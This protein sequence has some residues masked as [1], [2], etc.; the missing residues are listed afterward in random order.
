[1]LAIK[2]LFQQIS[3]GVSPYWTA[4]TRQD[5]EYLFLEC[6]EFAVIMG[7]VREALGIIR[8][9]ALVETDVSAMKERTPELVANIAKAFMPLH[10]KLKPLLP[11]T[12]S[13]HTRYAV[14]KLEVPIICQL[15]LFEHNKR[16]Q[17]HD[18]FVTTGSA[19]KRSIFRR[20]LNTVKKKV[21]PIF[22]ALYAF[23]CVYFL[24]NH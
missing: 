16:H 4:P 11:C 6:A 24:L 21:G 15:R 20:M 7:C 14:D 12:A 5:C 1:M 8:R 9:A 18:R 3:D 19:M 2:S 23:V 13:S 10:E 17:N 22:Y